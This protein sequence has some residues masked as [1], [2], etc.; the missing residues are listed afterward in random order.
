MIRV[1]EP[2]ESTADSACKAD[3]ADN[4]DIAD[5]QVWV[6]TYGSEFSRDFEPTVEKGDH[7]YQVR[8]LLRGLP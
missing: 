4:A 6:D 1:V 8:G 2:V 3:N 5:H 7:I